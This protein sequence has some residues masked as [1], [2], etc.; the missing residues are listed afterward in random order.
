MSA[1]VTPNRSAWRLRVGC[2][3]RPGAPGPAHSRPS[4]A[5]LVQPYLF[6][7]SSHQQPEHDESV[8]LDPQSPRVLTLKARYF[9]STR[10]ARTRS[11]RPLFLPNGG[12]FLVELARSSLCIP[13]RGDERRVF[14]P[15]GPR[16]F[17]YPCATQHPK[18]ATAPLR[19][20]PLCGCCRFAP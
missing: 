5:D 15:L 9:P 14:A 11:L 1:M 20:T 10:T 8:M 17:Q 18:C 2:A 6:R 13:T 4:A 12:L 3:A 7:R 19:R 16:T